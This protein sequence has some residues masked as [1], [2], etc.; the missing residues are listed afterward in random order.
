[1]SASE[2]LM[3]LLVG[4]GAERFILTET[5]LFVTRLGTGIPW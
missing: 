1:V 4:T 2:A 5:F 3:G